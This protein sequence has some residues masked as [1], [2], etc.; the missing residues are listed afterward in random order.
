[1]GRTFSLYAFPAGNTKHPHARG[2][3]LFSPFLHHMAVETPPR[4]W[5][6]P[7]SWLCRTDRSETPPRTWGEPG[8]YMPL[9]KVGRNTPTHVGRTKCRGYATEQISKH[10]HAR[11]ENALQC[12][13]HPMTQ[14]T[15]PRTWGEHCL[16]DTMQQLVRNTPTHVGRTMV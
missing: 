9:T 7:L 12:W 16:T 5:G 14:E 15:P 3:N 8:K 6:E 4:T 10:P 1:M 2:E 11:G 13:C